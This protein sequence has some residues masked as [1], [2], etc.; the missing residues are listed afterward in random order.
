MAETSPSFGFGIFSLHEE[1]HRS[2]D[3]VVTSWNYE[4]RI[5]WCFSV[6]MNRRKAAAGWG[7]EEF[8]W[9]GSREPRANLN[10]GDNGPSAETEA[11]APPALHPPPPPQVRA[12]ADRSNRCCL[13][14]GCRSLT[15]GKSDQMGDDCCEIRGWE[16]RMELSPSHSWKQW[17]VYRRIL[18][19]FDFVRWESG[20]G[21]MSAAAKRKGKCKHTLITDQIHI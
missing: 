7:K 6:R 3:S 10:K 16:Q 5:R 21:I 18:S 8:K 1:S 19:T 17:V 9:V 14:S 13:P 15:R 11:S 20:G 12:R 4:W 2:L